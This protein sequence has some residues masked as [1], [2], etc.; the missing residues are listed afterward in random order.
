MDLSPSP[1]HKH[2]IR[3]VYTAADVPLLSEHACSTQKTLSAKS[4]V[5]TKIAVNK[6]NKKQKRTSTENSSIMCSKSLHWNRDGL[7]CVMALTNFMEYV[8]QPLKL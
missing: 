4:V 5:R 1:E 3:L 8:A 6:N 7:D 2:L